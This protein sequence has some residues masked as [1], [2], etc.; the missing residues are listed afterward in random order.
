MGTAAYARG[1]L[2]EARGWYAQSL[3][4]LRRLK[5]VRSIAVALYNLIEVVTFSY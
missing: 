3:A 2:G 4:A 5:D 1:L